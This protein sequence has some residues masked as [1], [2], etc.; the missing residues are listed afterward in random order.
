MSAAFRSPTSARVIVRPCFARQLI[1]AV[2]IPPIQGGS[3]SAK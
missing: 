2:E 3:G 1:V